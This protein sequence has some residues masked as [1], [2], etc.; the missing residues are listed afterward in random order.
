MAMDNPETRTPSFTRHRTRT[1]TENIRYKI[2]ND[3]IELHFVI[4]YY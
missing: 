3:D 2:E 1:N 4:K